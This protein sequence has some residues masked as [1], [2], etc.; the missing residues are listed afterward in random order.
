VRFAIAKVQ[1]NGDMAIFFTIFAHEK[2]LLR[3]F[4]GFF[5]FSQGRDAQ[6]P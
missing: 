5:Q 2:V 3:F 1:K 6:P 4:C